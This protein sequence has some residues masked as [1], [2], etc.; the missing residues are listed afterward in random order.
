MI[1]NVT[2]TYKHQEERKS[3]DTVIYR[4]KLKQSLVPIGECSCH[5]QFCP[6]SQFVSAEDVSGPS[7][8]SPRLAPLS[9]SP[10]LLSAAMQ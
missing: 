6:L 4:S 10:G 9:G 2:C 3:K 7:P 1:I 8:S 5:L